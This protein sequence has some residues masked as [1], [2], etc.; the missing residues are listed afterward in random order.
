MKV[1]YGVRS[2]KMWASWLSPI[3]HLTGWQGTTKQIST[4]L[5]TGNY[6]MLTISGVSQVCAEAAKKSWWAPL[7]QT[8]HIRTYRQALHK[9]MTWRGKMTRALLLSA[10]QTPRP[11]A[12]SLKALR[13]R[14]LTSIEASYVVSKTSRGSHRGFVCGET[15]PMLGMF[16]HV[17]MLLIKQKSLFYW[18]QNLAFRGCIHA[19]V[20]DER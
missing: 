14:T 9:C 15:V 7:I 17:F 6:A 1:I 16:A 10:F 13:N 3:I 8:G 19:W 20:S 4:T 12:V 5:T 18:L 2:G 11:T